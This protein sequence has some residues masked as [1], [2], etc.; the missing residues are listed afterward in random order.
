MGH[1]LLW[2]GE[3]LTSIL[4]CNASRH[5]IPLKQSW[6]LGSERKWSDA[7][8]FPMSAGAWDASSM[9]VLWRGLSRARAMYTVW[10]VNY[11]FI[12]ILLPSSPVSTAIM[13]H[14][15]GPT[16]SQLNNQLLL[17]PPHDDPSPE[18]FDHHF[19]PSSYCTQ[20]CF[21]CLNDFRF[22]SVILGH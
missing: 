22:P 15:L 21:L 2:G 3:Y 1:P 20:T 12:L 16:P 8:G 19:H 6:E 7:W 17:C 10:E 13:S 14:F 4:S 9:G 11:L 5:K 18:K